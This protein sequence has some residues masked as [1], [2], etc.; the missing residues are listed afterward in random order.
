MTGGSMTSLAERLFGSAEK[1]RLTQAINET[2]SDLDEQIE[3]STDGARQSG[4]AKAADR[5]LNDATQWLASGKLEQGW[6]STQNAQR[7]IL[8]NPENKKRI[9]LVAISLRREADKLSGW[10]AKAITDLICGSKGELRPDIMENPERV[11]SAVELKD[12][13]SHNDYFKIAL[14]RRHLRQLFGILCFAIVACMFA[15]Y[16]DL[17]PQPYNDTRQ[18]GFVVLFGVLGA[19]ISV[20][21]GLLRSNVSVKIPVQKI[22][23]FVV[24]MRPAIGAAAA[25]AALAVID[26]NK[27]V[28]IL[29]LKDAQWSNIVGLL[30][31]AAGYSERFIVGAIEKFS[32]AADS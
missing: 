6:I 29:N 18:L 2:R 16:K 21:Q 12:D 31:L 8:A 4:W 32:T 7:A 24:W 14:R 10:R 3:R 1:E 30:A 19:C 15:S 27:A 23:A 17:L 9:E 13:Y 5:N 11:I 22:G 26:A 28:N 20:G 25:I